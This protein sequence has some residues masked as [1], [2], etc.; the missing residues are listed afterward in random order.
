MTFHEAN[1]DYGLAKQPLKMNIVICTHQRLAITSL[2]IET[3]LG[4]ANII[5]VVSDQSEVDYYSKYPITIIQFPNKPLGSKWQAGVNEAKKVGGPVMIL[6]S[7]DI[8][9]DD[10]I[11]RY[12]VLLSQGHNFIGLSR[13]YIHHQGKAYLCDYLPTRPLGGGR[14]YS[15]RFL[16]RIN[17][18]LFDVRRNH[19]LDR[20]GC[21]YVKD[22]L[23]LAEPLIHA[24]K[25]DWPVINPFDIKH[26]NVRLISVHD[27][28]DVLP[29]LYKNE[30]H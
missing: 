9:R 7:D 14:C 11:D 21:R 28:R 22:G 26:K 20:H 16:Q 5:L 12:N 30:I 13:W 19:G 24:V 23:I 17:Y 10:C 29:I 25:G 6:G 3:L 8:L 18:S 15:E 1:D 27:S 2:N 4:K